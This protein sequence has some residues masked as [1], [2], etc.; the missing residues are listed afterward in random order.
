MNMMKFLP[1]RLRAP[2]NMIVGGSV[3]TVIGVILN[4]W[5]AAAFLIPFVVIFTAWYYVLG[6]GDSDLAAV[7]LGQG[8]ER[9]AY[10]RLRMQALVGRVLS[11]AVGVISIVAV[12]VKATLWPVLVLV[13]LLPLTLLA[14]WAM[15][16]EHPDGREQQVGH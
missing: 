5:V 1:P 6:G 15:Y 13:G 3:I 14:G 12:A 4:G 16:R 8:D 7:V 10:R 9:Q 2:V 11:L